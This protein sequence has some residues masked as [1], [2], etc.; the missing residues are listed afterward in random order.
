[1]IALQEGAVD[2]EQRSDFDPE[3]RVSDF[4]VIGSGIRRSIKRACREVSTLPSIS[5]VNQYVAGQVFSA[6]HTTALPRC[7]AQR[8]STGATEIGPR[9]PVGLRRLL[10]LQRIPWPLTAL[11]SPSSRSY[12]LGRVR[13]LC[14]SSLDVDFLCDFDS[15][16]NLDAEI[17][18]GTL[19]LCVAE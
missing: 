9:L 19:D 4:P 13:Q 18:D 7:A 10:R 3:R 11:H 6:T 8:F 14:P 5:E 1:M 2:F 12:R 17:T 16:I 15:V